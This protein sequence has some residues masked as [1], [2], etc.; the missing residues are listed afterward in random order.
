MSI[1]N[2]LA[3]EMVP[4]LNV[5]SIDMQSTMR[6][7]SVYI[8]EPNTDVVASTRDR[9]SCLRID[10]DINPDT[11]DLYAVEEKHTHQLTRRKPARTQA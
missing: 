2:L 3:Q 5:H 9:P 4:F 7:I 1:S 6:A 8:A 11:F 10:P